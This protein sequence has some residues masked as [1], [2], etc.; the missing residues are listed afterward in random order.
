MPRLGYILD[1]AQSPEDCAQEGLD[2]LA[3]GPVWIAGGP[4]NFQ[5]AL[6]AA[7]HQPR[8]AAVLS[9]V[10]PPRKPVNA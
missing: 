8:S 5:T 1:T 2:N 6:D 3:N 7:A 9:V 4:N 10:P